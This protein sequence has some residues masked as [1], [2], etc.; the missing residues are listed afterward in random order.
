MTQFLLRIEGNESTQPLSLQGKRRWLL[1]RHPSCDIHIPDP[2]VSREHCLLTLKEGDVLEIEEMSPKNPTLLNNVPLKGPTEVKVGDVL[3]IGETNILIEATQQIRVRLVKDV[4]KLESRETLILDKTP[5]DQKDETLLLINHLADALL[6]VQSQE[7]ASLMTLELI[8]KWLPCRQGV[9][10]KI[11]SKNQ[12]Q[13]LATL[14]NKDKEA[15][16][17]ISRSLVQNLRKLKTPFCILDTS[18]EGGMTKVFEKNGGKPAGFF[19]APLMTREGLSGLIYLERDNQK[20]CSNRDLELAASLAKILSSR[21]ETID[22]IERLQQE[23]IDLQQQKRSLPPFLGRSQA[24]KRLIQL[25]EKL[26][27]HTH[28]ILLLGESGTGKTALARHIHFLK[29]RKNSSPIPSPF[30]ILDADADPTSS[31]SNPEPRLRDELFGSTKRGILKAGKLC[32]AHRGT[33]F[34]RSIHLLPKKLQ[35]DLLERIETSLIESPQGSFPLKVR[36]MASSTKSQKELLSE[37]QLIPELKQALLLNPVEIPPL[38]ERREDTPLLTSHF[39]QEFSKNSDREPPL[40]SPRALERICSYHW[41]RNVTE[42]REVLTTAVVLSRGH[43]IYPKH[44]PTHL[45]GKSSSSE[46]PPAIARP[47]DEVERDHIQQVLASVGGNK[48]RAA[49]ILGI[50]YSTLFAKLKKY[51]KEARS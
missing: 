39:L 32:A 44:L 10:S 31:P 15:T 24:W 19:V 41:P 35:V 7:D 43:Q 6:P 11:N 49:E 46:S 42:L 38:R 17:R 3:L 30:V 13:V 18:K 45:G 20:A 8:E 5:T 28:P 51:Q 29:N 23:N 22:L 47:L 50:A 34:I 16:I 1:G 37:N 14:S 40:L 2:R 26:V 25:A 27:F 21:L 12:L 36:L 9:I 48:L 33:L 4:E